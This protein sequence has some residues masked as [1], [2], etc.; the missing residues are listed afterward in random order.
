[1]DQKPQTLKGKPASLL[2]TNKQKNP[3]KF[4]KNMEGDSGTL[5]LS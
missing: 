4:M 2:K 3:Y 1:M 5:S